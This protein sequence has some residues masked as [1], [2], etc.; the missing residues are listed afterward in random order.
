[1]EHFIAWFNKTA[2]TGG[3]SV[4][5]LIRAGIT[6]LY[7][8]CIHPFEDGNGRI[9][10]ALTE[11]ALSQSLGVP[12]LITLSHTIQKNKKA[13]YDALGAASRSNEITA[14]LFYFSRVVLEAQNNTQLTIEFLIQKNKFYHVYEDRLNSRQEKVIT[15]IFKA[16][17]EGFEGGLSV[18]NY[19][20]ITGTSRATAT[21]DLQD[22]VSK[23][24]LIKSGQLKSTRYTLNLSN[25]SL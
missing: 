16:G 11:K 17:L 21:R 13:Y 14:W 22:L 5:A 9:A 1:M 24:A 15:R 25:V 3:A 8:V 2:P 20:R 6:H 18:D 23:G 10:R 4:P 12:L 19:L 7:F